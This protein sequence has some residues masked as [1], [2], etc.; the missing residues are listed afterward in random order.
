MN[1]KPGIKLLDEREGNGPPAQKG[2]H[3]TYNLRAYLSKGDE[4][5]VNRKAPGAEWPPNMLT[6]DERGEMIN[7]VCTI[8]K[9]EAIAAVEYSLVGMKEG[10][11]RKV[12]AKPHLAYGEAGVEGVVPKDAVLTIEIWLRKLRS[13][14]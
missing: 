7:F 11:Y 9:R 14:A 6:S 8:G 2:C 3:A 5:P 13:G 4:V 1:V 10:G 12:K